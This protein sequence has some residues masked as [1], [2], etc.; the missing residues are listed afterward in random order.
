MK[1][2]VGESVLVVTSNSSSYRKWAGNHGYEDELGLVYD[3]DDAVP[4]WHK[5]RLGSVLLVSRDSNLIGIGVV[6]EL[7]AS[8]KLKKY[9]SCPLCS[10]QSL[11]EKAGSLYSCT[12]CKRTYLQHE[13]LVITKPVTRIEAIYRESWFPA[14]TQLL[15]R[16]ILPLMKTKDVQSA[17][18]ELKSENLQRICKKLGIDC[19]AV[20]L[21]KAT[22]QAS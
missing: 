14:E 15:T 11:T 6:H 1:I 16:D 20:R 13:R 19:G 7:R 18:R 21:P 3:F 17:I 12:R 10:R 22:F 9:F 5:I 4:L 2:S 8:N